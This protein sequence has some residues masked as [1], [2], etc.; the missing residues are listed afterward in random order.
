MQLYV[1]SY[2]CWGLEWEL[3]SPVHVRLSLP[4]LLLTMNLTLMIINTP[5]HW[6]IKKKEST[7][8]MY[9]CSR[10]F[11]FHYNINILQVELDTYIYIGGLYIYI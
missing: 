3:N 11:R 2:S 8:N 9:L 7:R 10:S 5:L 4:V 1:V 6:A